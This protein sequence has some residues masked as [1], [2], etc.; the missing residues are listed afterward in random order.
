M[1]LQFI[2]KIGYN[3]RVWEEAPCTMWRQAA[4]VTIEDSVVFEE[5]QLTAYQTK[6]Q[7]RIQKPGAADS[8]TDHQR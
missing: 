4:A 6:H 3:V 5:T 1:R 2:S 7:H 8:F